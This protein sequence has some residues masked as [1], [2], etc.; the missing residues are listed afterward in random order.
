MLVALALGAAAAGVGTF[1]AYPALRAPV[2]AGEAGLA[3][4][5]VVVALA[6]FADRR[7]IER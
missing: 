2:G 1:A 6:P 7:G 3:V 4:V 5:I